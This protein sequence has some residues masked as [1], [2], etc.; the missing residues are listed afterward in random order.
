MGSRISTSILIIG[1]GITGCVAALTLADAGFDVLMVNS[2]PDMDSGNTALA[3]GGIVWKADDDE[4]ALLEQDMITAGW[5]L[6]YRPALHFLSRK[7][8]RAVEDMLIDRLKVPFTSGATGPSLTREGGHSRARIL[9]CADYTG[10]AIMDCLQRAVTESENITILNNRTAIDLLTTFHHSR[11]MALRYH[12][13]NKCVGAYVL[14][15]ETREVDTIFADFTLL[16]SGGLGQIFLHTTNTRHS[17]GSGLSMASRAGVKLV[18]IEFIQF[19]P[20]ALFHRSPRK[21]LISEAVRGEGAILINS[22]GERFMARYDERGEL[23]PRDI[24]TRSIVDEMLSCGDDCVYLD[25][26]RCKCPDVTERFPTIARQCR[27]I[28]VDISHDLIPVVPAAHYFC[29]GIL[30][31]IFGRTTLKRLYAA[32]ECACT[33]IHGANRLASTS[34]LEALVWGMSAG[35]HIAA[36]YGRMGRLTPRTRDSIGDWVNLG[37]EA[38]EDPALIAQDWA[39]I[40]HTMW[41]YVGI[42]RTEPRLRRAFEDLR[43]LN[44]CMHDFYKNT[45][46]SKPIV[47]L[48]HGC[49]SA[50]IIT[51]AAMR[52]KTTQGCHHR[53]DAS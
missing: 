15:S 18:N 4:P 3:Q 41:N 13:E 37:Q 19:H 29:G 50:Y 33:G 46:I 34:L 26:S 36:N 42:S 11:H 27:E 32:G 47:D 38:N 53:L 39:S 51:I 43:N 22:R 40:K 44:K 20:T 1:T 23:A 10:R 31:D 28:G 8:P 49:Q 2:G 45:P 17:V 14:N 9:Y 35:R 52:N 21:F 7:G 5:G 16:A 25:L 12:L 48:F 24:V 30:V 6:N